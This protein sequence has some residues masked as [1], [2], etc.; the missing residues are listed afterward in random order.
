MKKIL[1]SLLT[2]SCF[3]IAVVACG[4]G[5]GGGAPAPAPAPAANPLTPPQ[6]SAVAGS[7]VYFDNNTRAISIPVATA[8]GSAAFSA[9]ITIPSSATGDALITALT[10]GLVTST[11]IKG[12][13]II[14]S[15]ATTTYVLYDSSLTTATRLQTSSTAIES[16][17]VNNAATIVLTQAVTSPSFLGVVYSTASN[18]VMSSFSGNVTPHVLTGCT[19]NS[20]SATTIAN[21]IYGSTSYVGIGDNRGNVC[22]FNANN[23][24]WNNLTPQAVTHGYTASALNAFSF[25][26]I[27]NTTLYGY[28]Q[29]TNGQIWRVTANTNGQPLTS[30]SCTSNN[31]S[32]WQVNGGAQ[33]DPS[34]KQTTTFYNAPVASIVNSIYSDGVNNLWVGTTNGLVYELPAGS[35]NWTAPVSALAAGQAAGPVTLSGI[36]GS[37]TGVVATVATNN[38]FFGG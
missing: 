35:T 12:K 36:N 30:S 33:T 3:S 34:N 22:I 8:G 7:T 9:P 11:T 16:A 15:T 13:N 5:G 19:S 31:C 10:G 27:N 28:W 32:F 20:G 25:T 23:L 29:T 18:L 26:N 14:F 37:T 2:I 21:T 24:T 4:G 38:T 1:V 17:A 6:G